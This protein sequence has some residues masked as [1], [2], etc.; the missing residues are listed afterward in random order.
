MPFVNSSRG[1]LDFCFPDV[2]KTPTPVGPLPL[3]YP[4][5]ATLCTAMPV[6]F[7]LLVGGAPAHNMS[8]KPVISAGDNAGVAGGLISNMMMGPTQTL[9]GS[10]VLILKGMPAAKMLGMTGHNGTL[11]NGPGSTLVPSQLKVMA[12]R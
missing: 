8:S 11:P 9:L 3:P 4:N 5:M 12:L 6:C 7:N 10:T 1:G 2:C